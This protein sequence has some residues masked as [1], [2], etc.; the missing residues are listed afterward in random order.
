MTPRRLAALALASLGVLAVLNPLD[1][2]LTQATFR[3]NLALVGAAITWGLYSVL[4]KRASRDVGYDR[5]QFRRLPGWATSEP[6]A[7]GG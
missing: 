7:G 3:G 2:D 6:A 4:V 1:V 5:S